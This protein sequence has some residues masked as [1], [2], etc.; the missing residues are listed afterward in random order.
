MTFDLRNGD[1]GKGAEG[2]KQS[3]R[4][5][6]ILGVT[7]Y[8]CETTRSR[9]RKN[10]GVDILDI[11][12]GGLRIR[13]S[14]LVDMGTMMIVELRE[15]VTGDVFHARGVVRWVETVPG[16]KGDVHSI[17]LKFDEILTPLAKRGRFFHGWSTSAPPPPEPA[18]DVQERFPE[19]PMRPQ[20]DGRFQIDDYKVTASRPVGL[21]SRRKNVAAT[22][23]SLSA[24]GAQIECTE[25]LEKGARLQFTLHLNKFSDTFES[26]AEVAWVKEIQSANTTVWLTRLL[27]VKL[28][29]ARL[30]KLRNMMSWFTSYQAKYRRSHKP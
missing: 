8:R 10:V 19:T 27:F 6:E 29:D 1:S 26:E 24:D 2:R 14:E 16:P 9:V 25:K 21:L 22:V 7:C 5:P 20:T 13:V 4:R 12:P 15:P 28:D 30:R 11:S 3:R 18:R 17:G 23:V